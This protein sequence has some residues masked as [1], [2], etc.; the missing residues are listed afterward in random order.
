MKKVVKKPTKRRIKLNLDDLDE[1]EK[2]KIETLHWQID[3]IY[4]T[5]PDEL[6]DIK[7]PRG[8]TTWRADKL[9][10]FFNLLDKAVGSSSNHEFVR[11]TYLTVINGVEIVSR[12]GKILK[13]NGLTDCVSQSPTIDKAFKTTRD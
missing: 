11:T 6:K 5:F 13:L 7:R 2:K 4:R 9:E 12:K 8:Y 3:E 1:D 10:E